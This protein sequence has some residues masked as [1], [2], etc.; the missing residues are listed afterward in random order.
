MILI[1][2]DKFKGSLRAEEAARAIAEGLRLGGCV[3]AT[4]PRPM[5]DGGEGMPDEIEGFPVV[6]TSDL[7]GMANQSLLESPAMVRSSWALGQ[8]LM[9]HYGPDSPGKNIPKIWLAVGG[10]MTVDGGAGALQAMG[11]RFK[12]KRGERI[13]QPVAGRILSE[14]APLNKEDLRGFDREYWKKKIHILSDVRAA[15]TGPGLSSLDF[16]RQKGVRE[17]EME[18]LKRGLEH[19]REVLGNPAPSAVDGAGGGIGF[20]FGGFVEARYSS[21]AEVMLETMDVDWDEISMIITGEGCI[22]CQTAGGKV[23]DVLR[24]KAASLRIP[25]HAIGGYVAPEFRDAFTHSTIGRPEDYDPSHACDRLREAA[26]ALA[27]HLSH[28]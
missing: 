19:L 26:S 13:D 21:G 18:G 6:S 15:L 25:C 10:T 5:A 3:E 22:D 12:D 7:V 4:L 2:P 8:Y 20:A 16:A 28:F 1:A 11:I 27:T 14:L 23:V 24:R 9:Q 17:E